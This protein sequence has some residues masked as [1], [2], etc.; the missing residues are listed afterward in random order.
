MNTEDK[1]QKAKKRVKE[2]RGFYTHLVVYV[3]VNLFV[4][5]MQAAGSTDTEA[6]VGAFNDPD[7]TFNYF[8]FTD[9]KL[10]GIELWGIRRSL[11]YVTAYSVIRDGKVDQLDLLY[12]AVP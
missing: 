11:P 3:S 10:G 8:G 2:I 4:Q 1:Y 9:G 12:P 5:A 7:L 6:V